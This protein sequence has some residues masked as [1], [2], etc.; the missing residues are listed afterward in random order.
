MTIT[1]LSTF[2]LMATAL[3]STARAAESIETL[4][5]RTPHKLICEGY[6][7][8]NW[9]L[10]IMNADGSKLRN[11][12]NTA[13]SHEIYPQASPDGSMIAFLSDVGAGR[14]TVRSLWVMDVTGENRRKISD[15][16]RQPFW[17]PDSK[18]LAYLP[19]E[20]KKFSVIDYSTKGMVFHN[21][22]TGKDRPHPNSGKIHHLYN[23]GFSP[24][25]K[26]IVATVHSGMG[27][28]HGTLLIE[29]DGK[30]IVNLKTGG[31][32]P[33]FSPS[34][35]F[36][37]WGPGDHEIKVVEFDRAG[38][39]P[40]LGKTRLQIFHKK[41]KI[42][43]VDWCPNEQFLTISQGKPGK[44]NPAMPGTYEAAS[45]IVGVHA[46]GWNIVA[47]AI[48]D[49]GTVDLQNPPAGR[50]LQLTNDGRSYKESEWISVK[51]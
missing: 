49:G 17:S 13:D 47:I 38:D 15:Y 44:G 4:L 22:E 11:L 36:L 14:T 46:D 39:L 2:L 29:A 51:Q 25:G 41:D 30:R 28:G 21:L 43:H 6:A 42:Y 24:D 40:A 18:T 16:A 12:T 27:L 31:C 19:Q 1:R 26:W 7:N 23:P 35:K 20:F 33:T 32:R 37:A 48:G 34:G 45:E 50:V 10:F 3:D 5:A 9:E 8:N